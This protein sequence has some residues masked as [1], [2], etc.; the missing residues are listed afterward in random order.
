MSRAIFIVFIVMSFGCNTAKKSDGACNPNGD[1]HGQCATGHM[2]IVSTHV[3]A[4]APSTIGRS[5]YV[6][7]DAVGT[8]K[9]NDWFCRNRCDYDKGRSDWLMANSPA[10]ADA[11]H[12]DRTYGTIDVCVAKCLEVARKNQ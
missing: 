1:V 6:P 9:S 12:F 7:A 2:C 8:C 3:N 4:M 11:G 5:S 10:D